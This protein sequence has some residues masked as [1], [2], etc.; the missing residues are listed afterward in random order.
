MAALK[1]KYEKESKKIAKAEQKLILL[2][3]G[4][5]AR[6]TKLLENIASKMQELRDVQTDTGANAQ[7]ALKLP[8]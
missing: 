2:T 5:E 8:T 1:S 4:Y 6:K 7:N 3:Q